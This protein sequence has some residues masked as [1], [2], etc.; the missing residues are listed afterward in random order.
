MFSELLFPGIVLI[1]L[2]AKPK[3]FSS[4]ITSVKWVFQ[5]L[6]YSYRSCI[7]LPSF[8]KSFFKSMYSLLNSFLGGLI[9]HLL[10]QL[11]FRQEI[12]FHR[13][14]YK[15]LFLTLPANQYSGDL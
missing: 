7:N 11:A 6:N 1:F 5:I 14:T 13:S 15:L 3:S 12:V 8:V 10:L 4:P 2:L 9:L